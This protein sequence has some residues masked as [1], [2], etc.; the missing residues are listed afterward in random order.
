MTE[1]MRAVYLTGHDGLESVVVGKRQ[2]PEPGPGEVLIKVAASSINRVDL[3]MAN[4]G[5]GFRHE[6]PLTLGVDGAGVIEAVGPYVRSRQPGERVVLYSSRFGLDEFSRRGDQMLSYARELTGENI[7]GCMADYVVMPEEC[8]FPISEAISFRDAATLSTAYLT[9][10]RS[11]VTQGQVTQKDWVL[12]HGVGGGASMAAL[13]FCALRRAKTIVTSSSDAK[14]E[15]AREHGAT[16]VVNYREQNVLEEVRRLTERRGV[17]VVIENVGAETWDTSLRSAVGGGRIVVFGATTGANPKIDLQRV[18]IRQLHIIGATI[19]NFE[20]FRTLIDALERNLFGPLIDS[21]VS[22]EDV[23]RG[24]ARMAAGEQVGKIS[25]QV[26]E[27]LG[28]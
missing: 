28:L 6:L 24:L 21:V 2:K 16:H 19:G 8:A 4:D 20:E 23:P 18:F 14:L 26:N 12:I 13:Q 15:I 9:A 10:W 3:Y 27:S 22:L 11:V 5:S 7:D 17:D 1:M 25:V